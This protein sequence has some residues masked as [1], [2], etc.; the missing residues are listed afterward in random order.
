MIY[1]KLLFLS[2]LF[3]VVLSG[4]VSSQAVEVNF[5]KDSFYG[6]ETVQAEVFVDGVESNLR[7]NMLNL[8]QNGSSVSFSPHLI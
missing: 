8:F 5:A 6:G 4:F 1:L 7:S 3:L 2:L